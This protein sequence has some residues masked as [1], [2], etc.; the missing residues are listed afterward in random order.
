MRRFLVT[1]LAVVAAAVP[2][3]PAAAKEMS[4][5]L[6]SGPPTLD[7]GQP[8]MAE[9]V[10][11]GVPDMLEQATPGITFT[12]RATGETRTFDG[13]A[14]GERAPDGQFLL[15]ARVVLPEGLW[16]WGL[17]DGVTDRLYEGGLVRVS[18]P[19]ASKPTA[20]PES[21]APV[22]AGDR[23]SPWPFVLVGSV[24]L[25]GAGAALARRARVQPTA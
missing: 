20:A 6:A 4:V 18:Q 24:V 17:T 11:H 1:A 16:R 25:L 2:A 22:S 10:V 5:S 14:T 7:A 23:T 15:R 8:W 12:N 19:A 21:P 13:K 3:A 9:L